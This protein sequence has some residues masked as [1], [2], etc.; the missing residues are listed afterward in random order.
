MKQ[1]K[2]MSARGTISC[3]VAKTLNS[4]IQSRSKKDSNLELYNK[5][6]ISELSIKSKINQGSVNTSNS[7]KVLK[8]SQDWKSRPIE[9]IDMPEKK[10]LQGIFS[11]NQ[12][13]EI[14]CYDYSNKANIQKAELKRKKRVAQGSWKD[15][16][17]L[18]SKRLKYKNTQWINKGKSSKKIVGTTWDEF[19]DQK[20]D[21]S[22]DQV[23]LVYR[24]KKNSTQRSS[25]IV[26]IYK[27]KSRKIHEQESGVNSKKKMVKGVDI[28]AQINKIQAKFNI[29][30]GKNKQTRTG[31]KK[32]RNVSPSLN[33]KKE[34]MKKQTM[35]KKS[36]H[37][38][39]GR[40]INEEMNP[41]DNH[42]SNLSQYQSLNYS[43][44]PMIK[45]K[46][47]SVSQKK[48]K[49]YSEQIKKRPLFGAKVLHIRNKSSATLVE[50]KFVNRIRP[51]KIKKISLNE[52]KSMH[53][54]ILANLREQ[55]YRYLP[56][57]KSKNYF[58]KLS[59]K[60]FKFRKKKA[61]IHKIK[62]FPVTSDNEV[63]P[64]SN[65]KDLQIKE[66]DPFVKSENETNSQVYNIDQIVIK[67]ENSQKE[68]NKFAS[69]YELF[70]K[71]ETRDM[72]KQRKPSLKKQSGNN[73]VYE[74]GLK[75]RQKRREH[76]EPKEVIKKS[77]Q[78][79]K[80]SVYKKSILNYTKQKNRKNKRKKDKNYLKDFSTLR[81]G[82]SFKIKEKNL[83]K[84]MDK[85]YMRG[86]VHRKRGMYG[87]DK[88]QYIGQPNA[89]HHGVGEKGEDKV[90]NSMT[91][92][93]IQIENDKK[94]PLIIRKPR[95]YIVNDILE[96]KGFDMNVLSNKNAKKGSKDFIFRGRTKDK[97]KKERKKS[98]SVK[99][100][101]NN[102]R[103][104]VAH[105]EKA[106]AK[107]KN[108][109][110]NICN[111]AKNGKKMSGQVK[112]KK[113]QKRKMQNLKTKENCELKSPKMSKILETQTFEELGTKKKGG[114]DKKKKK[115][116]K[117][118]TKNQKH[119]FI[120][121]Q[122]EIHLEKLQ[123]SIMEMQ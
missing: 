112:I 10:Q 115:I 121:L 18:K 114:N 19:V 63:H 51:K 9:Y 49:D 99:I 81:V 80:K 37:L 123:S 85:D 38:K 83:T 66:Y 22:G 64:M 23:N 78:H 50:N 82:E 26:D 96:K 42:Q 58:L 72:K 120:Q 14:N 75:V 91:Q 36:K 48:F 1:L 55:S 76:S 11:S 24:Q 68:D 46:K 45:K 44:D 101:I 77:L 119:N 30:L 74:E 108:R 116:G 103:S 21:I 87:I 71:V 98:R 69:H 104:S 33:S 117:L 84:K 25:R 32:M 90:A 106:L 88:K 15:F 3:D 31:R 17:D 27:V 47:K 122:K 102:I 61:S 105:L 111:V 95:Q 79:K 113:I 110:K 56:K 109:L 89:H 39:L 100:S 6:G 7:P 12:D 62:K 73:S 28:L 54:E 67:N 35:Q 94:V 53:S 20:T 40:L 4:R 34:K 118:S 13:N 107:E 70:D 2:K 5:I 41:G 29:D 43:V 52:Q 60:T 57:G 97:E 8:T 93:A 86:N 59:K 16:R 92:N 65:Q